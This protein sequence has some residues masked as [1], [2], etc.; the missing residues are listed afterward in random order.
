MELLDEA[1]RTKKQVRVEYGYPGTDFTLEPAW[2]R[3]SGEPFWMTVNPYRLTA[4]DGRYFLICNYDKYDT[5]AIYRV[6]RMIR[7]EL[8]DTPA[9]PIQEV[10]RQK[11]MQTTAEFVQSNALMGYGESGTVV[12]SLPKLKAYEAIDV[13]GKTVSFQPDPKDPDSLICTVFANHYSMKRWALQYTDI[14]KVLSPGSL[15]DEIKETL[16]KGLKNYEA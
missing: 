9:K 3:K 16:A 7:C 15:A 1:I 11:S 5:L 4:L 13:F 14:V 10:N 6:D 2:K 12:F 8:L